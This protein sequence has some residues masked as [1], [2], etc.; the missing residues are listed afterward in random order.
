[1][2]QDFPNILY[3]GDFQAGQALHE[4]V[5]VNEWTVYVP[6]NVMEAL[7][8][9]ITYCPDIVIIEPTVTSAFAKQVHYHL[10]TVE[11]EPMIMLDQ[12]PYPLSPSSLIAL[13]TDVLHFHSETTN[14]V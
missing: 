8:M 9:Y 12:S 14:A 5:P 3:I 11:A 2:S 4:V 13:I 6:T 10:Q 7:G 1:M